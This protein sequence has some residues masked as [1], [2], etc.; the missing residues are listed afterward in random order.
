MIF[1]YSLAY[2]IGW[3]PLQVTYVVEI[4][5]YNLRARVSRSH[6]YDWTKV[7]NVHRVLS[8]TIFSWLWL[9]SLTNTPTPL[10]SPTLAGNVNLTLFKSFKTIS[11]SP[12][13]IL[14]TTSGCSS[15]F[16]LSTFYLWRRR[17]HHWKKLLQFWMARRFKKGLR[18][19]FHEP[20]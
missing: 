14:F 3:G 15:R 12:Q 10:E 11:N 2:N 13:T 1:L 16:W 17:A 5:P 7:A 9:S 20:Q 19:G 6:T 4:L 18:K 8:S